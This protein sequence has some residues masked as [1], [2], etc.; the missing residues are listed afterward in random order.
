MHV[1]ENLS[2]VLKPRQKRNVGTQG[3]M[4]LER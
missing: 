1:D 4:C 3:V 2:R